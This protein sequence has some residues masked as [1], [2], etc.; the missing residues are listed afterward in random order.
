MCPLIRVSFH[1]KIQSALWRL[2]VLIHKREYVPKLGLT[3]EYEKL[4]TMSPA[5]IFPRIAK[6]RV[7]LEALKRH[8]VNHSRRFNPPLFDG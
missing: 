3:I 2:F 7:P 8:R 6:P 4:S 1:F 5:I